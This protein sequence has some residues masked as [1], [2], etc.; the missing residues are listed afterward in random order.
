MK[1]CLTIVL[2]AATL[3][4]SAQNVNV[5]NAYNYMGSGEYAKA[6][7]YIEPAT[8]DAKTS[9]NEKTWRYRGEIYRMIAMGEDAS[10][11]AM[12]P[13]AIDKAIDSYLKANELDTKGAYKTENMRALNALQAQSLNTGNDAF[14][15]KEYDKA[16]ALYGNSERI[17]KA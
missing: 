16:I 17:A 6:A 7:E 15:A 12:F 9:V 5:V 4:L 11:K 2:S 1:T 13:D 10:L 14:T 3:G 8:Q